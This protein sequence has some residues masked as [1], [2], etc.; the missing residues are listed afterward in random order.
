VEKVHGTIKV[1]SRF[2]NERITVDK[3]FD[4]FLLAIPNMLKIINKEKTPM[5]KLTI[6][7]SIANERDEIVFIPFINK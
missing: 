3:T 2:K 5:I 1:R 4:I 6:L 7:F